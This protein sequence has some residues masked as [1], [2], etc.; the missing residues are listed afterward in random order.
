MRWIGGAVGGCV[1][2]V[3]AA[4][5]G[6]GVDSSCGSYFDALVN[7]FNECGAA[8]LLTIN[9]SDR[10]AFVQDCVALSKAPGASNIGSQLDQC[11][12]SL[13]SATLC[14]LQGLSCK[15][16][17]S[18]PNGAPCATSAQCSGG[19]CDSSGT[20]NPTSEIVCGVCASDVPVGGSCTGT[21]TCDPASGS[22]VNGTCVAYA[23]QGAACGTTAP[24]ATCGG[25]L[26]CTNGTCQPAPTQGQACTTQCLLPYR[27]ISGTCAQA[28]AQG[29]ACKSGEVDCASGLVCTNGQ[30]AQPTFAQVGQP[31]GA[32]TTATCGAGLYCDSMSTTCKARVSS[33]G[34]CTVGQHQCVE[35]LVCVS[36][37]CQQPDYTV[38]K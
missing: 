25:S 26:L 23:T 3:A 13:S 27:C 4:S 11:A 7:F 31:C 12:S 34:A 8:G 9:S 22:C 10:A 24:S 19:V 33:G 28:V 2:L 16:A 38:C 5:C 18:Q 30:C 20:T 15:L 29:G 36:G 35:G 6:G 37:T 32:Q 17:G 21:A 14:T 1:V